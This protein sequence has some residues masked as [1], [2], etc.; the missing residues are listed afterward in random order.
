MIPIIEFSEIDVWCLCGAAI[1]MLFDIIMGLAG[2]IIRRDFS[3]T[4]MREGLG[5]K[6]M[7]AGVIILAC[8]MQVLAV[9]ITTLPA[10]PAVPVVCV[11]VIVMEVG[12]I[13]ETI[14][15]TYPEITDTPINDVFEK[16]DNGKGGENDGEDQ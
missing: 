16:F 11:Y 8:I 13:W 2:A 7:V 10:F 6:V 3:S 12:S 14:Q 15:D 9:H 4:V 1:L 5:H